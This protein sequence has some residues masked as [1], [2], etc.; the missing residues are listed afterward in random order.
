[1]SLL[2]NETLFTDSIRLNLLYLARHMGNTV[3]ST[4]ENMK[5]VFKNC[6]QIVKQMKAISKNAVSR[7]D[8]E[9][10]TLVKRDLISIKIR[11]L[12]KILKKFDFDLHTLKEPKNCCTI[13]LT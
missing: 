12:S 7:M 1:M 11:K 2:K 8:Y 13:E 4:S 9:F 5:T 10:K 3:E 6:H